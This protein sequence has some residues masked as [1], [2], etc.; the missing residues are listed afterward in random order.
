MVRWGN[1]QCP[2]SLGQVTISYGNI[3]AAC[4]DG[5]DCTTGDAFDAACNCVGTLVDADGDG[6]CAADDCDDTDASV[7]A[8]PGTTCDDGDAT[9][10]NDVYLADG[11]TCEGTLPNINGGVISTND[12][13]E[14]CAGDGVGDPIDVTLTGEAGSNTIWVITD[15]DSNIL[16]LP[17]APPFDLDGA[18]P[19][20]CLIWH[21]SYEAGLAGLEVGS[22]TADFSG[23]YDLSNPLTVTRTGVDGGTISTTDPT[24]I[25]AG[26]GIP[27]PIEVA[28]TD[29][30]GANS[31]WVITDDDLNILGLPAAPP[32]DL[33]G[34]GEG[35]CLIWHLSYEDGL[36]GAEL[37]LNTANLEGCYDLSNPITVTRNLPQ[38]GCNPTYTIANGTITVDG[39]NGPHNS[40]NLFDT[41]N[42]WATAFSCFDDCGNP[43]EINVPEGNYYI[44]IKVLDE[45]YQID[46]EVMEHI[47]VSGVCTLEGTACN[48]NDPCTLLDEYDADCNCVGQTNS[49]DAD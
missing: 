22:N 44:H 42:G 39:L 27:D 40:I 36:I 1:T 4:D 8:T 18:G 15:D 35:V 26:D 28:L 19:G 33:E 30:I 10:V 5:D 34:E 48:D 16:A 25:I 23:T 9:T 41:H 6:I 49:P 20:V 17:A 12:P 47:T 38:T 11:C 45:S 31:T 13:T 21:L 7:P 2:T 37:G 46:C 43:A 3:G 14:I 32:F 29:E 24:T